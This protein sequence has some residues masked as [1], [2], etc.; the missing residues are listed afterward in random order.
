ME[1]IYS[2]NYNKLELLRFNSGVDKVGGYTDFGI[3][4]AEDLNNRTEWLHNQA[5]KALAD[6]RR[7]GNQF[8]PHLNVTVKSHVQLR[9]VKEAGARHPAMLMCSATDFYPK[10]IRVYRLKDGKPVTS[11]VTSS[12]ETADGD[13]YFQIH[14]YLEYIPKSGE[15]ISCMVDYASFRKKNLC[16]CT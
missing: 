6:C 8:F 3:K 13:L 9:S 15:R 1:L 2:I 5:S 12:E 10:L 14:S 4:Y 7:Y 16:Y 11:D